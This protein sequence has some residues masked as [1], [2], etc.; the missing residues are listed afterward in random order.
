MQNR[1]IARA[2]KVGKETV[3][4]TLAAVEAWER[5][6]HR[7]VRARE[8]AALRLWTEALSG[9]P[10]IVAPGLLLSRPVQSAPR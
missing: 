8:Q 7:A 5:R 10:G 2:M 3:A 1:G 6:D 4:G 9:L